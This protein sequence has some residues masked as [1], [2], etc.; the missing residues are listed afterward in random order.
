M[1]GTHALVLISAGRKGEARMLTRELRQR[2]RLDNSRIVSDT[3]RKGQG[4][5]ATKLLEQVLSPDGPVYPRAG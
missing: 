2:M 4:A 3:L 1:L 5:Y